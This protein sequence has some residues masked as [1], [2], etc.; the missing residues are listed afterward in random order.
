MDSVAVLDEQERRL[1]FNE[2]AARMGFAPWVAEKDFWVCWALKRLFALPEGS[3]RL[4]FKGGTS[5]SKVF[6]IIRRFSEDIDLSINREDLG[7]T[8]ER[9][10]EALSGNARRRM[11]EELTHAVQGFVHGELLPRLRDDFSKVFQGHVRW[12]IDSVEG[13]PNLLF[14]YPVAAATAGTGYVSQSILIE[15]GARSDHSPAGDYGVNPYAYD[16]F[17]EYFID[18]SCTVRVMSAERTFW[19]KATI[20]HAYYHGGVKR[21]EKDRMSRHY[22]DLCQ[23]AKSPIGEAAIRQ[24][25]LLERV[26]IHKDV[27]FRSAWAHYGEARP[28]SLRL[29]PD[30]ELA[31]VVSR[32]FARMEAEGY[33]YGGAPPD[34]TE[35]LDVLADLESEINR[36]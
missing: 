4:L 28:G 10:P 5:L 17:P 33:F 18:P 32:D 6:G 16:H 11:L 21:A 7:F 27:Y 19:E 20:L 22:Y 15:I 13:S 31:A 34:F 29:V 30:D 12:A 9:D 24:T 35:I 2:T 23:L 36:T 3:P 14:E 26:R 8:G 1:L 25:D